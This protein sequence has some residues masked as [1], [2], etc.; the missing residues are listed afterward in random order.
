MNNLTL[1]LFFIELWLPNQESERSCTCLLWV[2]NFP[3]S[4]IFRFYRGT[5]PTVWYFSIWSWNCS[6]CVVF[7]YFIV[8]LFQLCG[9]FLFYRGTVPTVWYFSILS[10]NCSNCVVFF[11][12]HFMTQFLFNATQK[13]NI[14]CFVHWMRFYFQ[15]H[16]KIRYFRFVWVL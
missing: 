5:V 9:I 8:E 15:F 14:S 13:M 7:F 4:T 6:N 16:V 11:V 1:P 2:S 12:F 3:V 10:W